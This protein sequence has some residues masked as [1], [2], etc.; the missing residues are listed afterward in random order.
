MSH[1]EATS[2]HHGGLP[3]G[4]PEARAAI[5]RVRELMAP[6]RR[7][8]PI[9]INNNPGK[10]ARPATGVITPKSAYVSFSEWLHAEVTRQGLT[11]AGLST[12]TGIARATIGRYRDGVNLPSPALT[13]KLANGLGVNP[14]TIDAV[15]GRRGP[16]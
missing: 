14:A 8:V 5:A 15:C 16:Q 4:S 12:M 7:R 13:I 10:P 9:T 2:S 11:Y 6:G 1:T 3:V